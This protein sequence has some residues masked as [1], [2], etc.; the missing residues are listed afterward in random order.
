MPDTVTY[1]TPIVTDNGLIFITRPHPG[2]VLR[3]PPATRVCHE[4]LCPEPWCRALLRADDGH[5]LK[6][7]RDDEAARHDREDGD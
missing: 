1:A 4:T 6:R 3:V 2:T 5:A 7:L